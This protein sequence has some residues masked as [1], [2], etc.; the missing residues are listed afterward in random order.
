MAYDDVGAQLI[1]TVE[2]AL[3]AR[4]TRATRTEGVARCRGI[5]NAL[6]LQIEEDAEPPVSEVV[7]LLG[8]AMVLQVRA[9]GL[10]S[11]RVSLVIDKLI[12]HLRRR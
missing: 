8:K 1:R 7:E 12:A 6:E 2:G 10:D 9:E 4:G 3:P 11:G 5:L